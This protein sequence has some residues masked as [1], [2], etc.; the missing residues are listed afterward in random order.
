ME[1]IER[2]EHVIVTAYGD[3]ESLEKFGGILAEVAD[4]GY[5]FFVTHRMM[6]IE[7]VLPVDALTVIKDI[8]DKMPVWRV[9]W[10]GALEKISG[11]R[12]MPVAELRD[13]L[14]G[15]IEVRTLEGMPQM[16]RLSPLT[17]PVKTFYSEVKTMEV[18]EDVNR[19]FEQD[20][21]VAEAVAGMDD[22]IEA[23]LT[24]ADAEKETNDDIHP[25]PGSKDVPGSS[26]DSH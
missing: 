25:E 16:A 15:L 24:A 13:K 26:A 1:S 5:V 4:D 20:Q 19:V 9:R 21:T 7:K 11:W 6:P 2:G 8:V 14:R 3:G 17:S 22:E 23:L 12:T 10:A 18:T